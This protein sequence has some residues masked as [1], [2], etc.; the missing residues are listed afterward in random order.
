MRRDPARHVRW[1]VPVLVSAG[2]AAGG[3][4]SSKPGYCSAQT[5]LKNDVEGLTKVSSLSGLQSQLQKVQ[6]SASSLVSSAKSDFPTQADA[7]KS[8]VSAL[9]TTLKEAP[10]NPSA[11]RQKAP[12]EIHAVVT[13]VN[14]FANATKSKCS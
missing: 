14:E 12:A 8:S 13:S 2:L 11:A 6:A 1:F 5:N 4:G 10:S 9:V 3:C 7:V